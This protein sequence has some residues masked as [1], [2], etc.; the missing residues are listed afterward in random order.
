MTE[1]RTSVLYSA[2]KVRNVDTVA[3]SKKNGVVESVVNALKT[4]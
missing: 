2:P 3:E 1:G 4:S